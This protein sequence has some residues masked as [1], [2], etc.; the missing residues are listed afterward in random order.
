[1]NKL[2]YI[3]SDEALTTLEKNKAL[4]TEKSI[5]LSF[6]VNK[7][8][9]ATVTD[10]GIAII[11]ACGP[12][13]LNTAPIDRE[14][15]V[16]DYKDIQGELKAAA[17]SEEIRG[18]LLC[19]NSPGGTV[20][21]CKETAR[22]VE[23]FP[24]PLVG[25]VEGMACSAGYKLVCGADAVFATETS[26][27][28]N[29]GSVLAYTD[30]SELMKKMGVSSEAITNEGADLKSTFYLGSLTEEQKQFLQERINEAGEQFKE[31]VLR[32]RPITP[33]SEVFRAGW[34][35]GDTAVE[36]GLIDGIASLEEAYEELIHYL[37]QVDTLNKGEE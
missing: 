26:T 31:H 5:D 2:F 1:M 3:E 13:M 18:V 30:Y 19:I 32:N 8:P 29:I 36:L 21:G 27:V 6:W 12:M 23:E 25:H 34:Y 9:D 28:G 11:H 37:G 24:K 4:A 16:T 22:I 14:L 7:K 17:E 15:G 33:D 35:S 20:L 10:Q